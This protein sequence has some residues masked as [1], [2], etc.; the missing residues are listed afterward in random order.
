MNMRQ[1]VHILIQP[2]CSNHIKWK[3]KIEHF[4]NKNKHLCRPKTTTKSPHKALCRTVHNA[5]SK[6]LQVSWA[7][8]PL[9]TPFSILY[10]IHPS[11]HMT[12]VT[13]ERK[14]EKNIIDHQ[15][16]LCLQQE[17]LQIKYNSSVKPPAGSLT[18]S[19]ISPFE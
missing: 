14:L 1:R 12:C 18:G 11:N 16:G 10:I 19:P 2:L 5:I 7:L 3:D 6:K 13:W 8:A 15:L 4:K 9:P 17:S